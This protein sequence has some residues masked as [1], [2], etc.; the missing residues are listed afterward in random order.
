MA[1]VSNHKANPVILNFDIL[2]SARDEGNVSVVFVLEPA[3]QAAEVIG[4]Y[5]VIRWEFQIHVSL[6]LIAR[7]VIDFVVNLTD[8]A[9]RAALINAGAANAPQPEE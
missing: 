1:S 5:A 3:A 6:F 4:F 8:K 7:P 9:F 2:P